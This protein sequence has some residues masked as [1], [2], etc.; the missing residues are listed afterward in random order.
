MTT[1]TLHISKTTLWN[2][3]M[4][5]NMD[6]NPYWPTFQVNISGIYKAK[7]KYRTSLDSLQWHKR[8][9]NPWRKLPAPRRTVQE[10]TCYTDKLHLILEYPALQ[11][12]EFR[13]WWKI[14]IEILWDEKIKQNSKR[15]EE[16]TT[17]PTKTPSPTPPPPHT[18]TTPPPTKKH[19]SKT[20]KQKNKP[21]TNKNKHTNKHKYFTQKNPLNK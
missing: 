21:K 7:I 18:H 16:K 10:P 17:P 6:V 1:L 14:L 13:E 4:I 3:L 12:R 8:K 19:P 15:G 11:L 5:K 20:K 9:S 2:F